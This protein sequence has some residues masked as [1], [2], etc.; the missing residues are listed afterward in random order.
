VGGGDA[1]TIAPVVA[2][3]AAVLCRNR[4]FAG[5]ATPAGEDDADATCPP[6]GEDE[7]EDED[8]NEDIAAAAAA[9]AAA[10]EDAEDGGEPRSG[11]VTGVRSSF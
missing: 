2:A 11:D 3:R 6:A 7:D 8:E 4:S 10:G 1:A 5:D 9:V